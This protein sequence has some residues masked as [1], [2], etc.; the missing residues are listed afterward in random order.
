[1]KNKKM[2][3]PLVSVLFLTSCQVSLFSFISDGGSSQPTP[4]P[5]DNPPPSQP[6]APAKE[7]NNTW[8]TQYPEDGGLLPMGYQVIQI[9]N[10]SDQGS[11]PNSWMADVEYCQFNVSNGSIT[12]ISHLKWNKVPVGYDKNALSSNAYI[13]IDSTVPTIRQSYY[14]DWA[15]VL[16]GNR[17]SSISRKLSYYTS[18]LQ[19]LKDY[20]TD[21]SLQSNETWM[22]NSYV[23]RDYV[24]NYYKAFPQD[25]NITNCQ[26]K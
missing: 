18:D 5:P 14:D 24:A 17:A 12:Y 4:P 2:L 19:H 21:N 11:D 7:I 15:V 13:V 23:S 20:Y 8:I 16:N 1:M 3:F 25:F 10:Y 26:L 22:V 6:T 9:S